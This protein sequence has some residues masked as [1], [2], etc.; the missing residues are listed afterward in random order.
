M[1]DTNHIAK[2]DMLKLV[3]GFSVP[4]VLA[5]KKNKSLLQPA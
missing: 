4:M 2:E 3:I 1:K 5:S